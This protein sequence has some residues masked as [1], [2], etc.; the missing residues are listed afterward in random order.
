M[1]LTRVAELCL[2]P[3]HKVLGLEHVIRHDVA[4]DP[5]IV[6]AL[7]GRVPLA[8]VLHQQ[9]AD[10]VL[11]C[12]LLLLLL[13]K[14]RMSKSER[15]AGVRGRRECVPSSDTSSQL[16]SSKSYL[17]SIIFLNNAGALSA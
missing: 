8:R 2:V 3:L 12:G 1:A 5:R 11:G 17:T 13:H 9:V 16:E 14:T 15:A 10:E 6:Q 7:L 4:L